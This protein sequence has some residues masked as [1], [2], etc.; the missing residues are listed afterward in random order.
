MSA[1]V[2]EGTGMRR[3]VPNGA[4]RREMT[5]RACAF[6]TADGMK[7]LEMVGVARRVGV[8][9]E[10]VPGMRQ[11]RAARAVEVQTKMVVLCNWTCA[12]GRRSSYV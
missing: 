9:L 5:L 1:G 2:V 6:R 10:I 12:N 3:L 7:R 4:V 11:R 8:V